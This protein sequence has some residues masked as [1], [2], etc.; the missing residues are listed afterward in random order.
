MN[1][2]VCFIVSGV[3]IST[4]ISFVQHTVSYIV[5]SCMQP[6][7]TQRTHCCSCATTIVARARHHIILY[8]HCL[9]SSKLYSDFAGKFRDRSKNCAQTISCCVLSNSSYHRTYKILDANSNV[10]YRTKTYYSQFEFT[11]SHQHGLAI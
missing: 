6:N 4:K 3:L 1:T 5:D 8:V 11:I 2:Y 10:N 9:Y 7:N